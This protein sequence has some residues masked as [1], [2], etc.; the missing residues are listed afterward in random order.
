LGRSSRNVLQPYKDQTGRQNSA[1]SHLRTRTYLRRH[2]VLWDRIAHNSNLTRVRRS[3][4]FPSEACCA[5]RAGRRRPS[6]WDAGNF[7]GQILAASTRS[8][9]AS[10]R[11]CAP[12]CL[13]TGCAFTGPT[14]SSQLASPEAGSRRANDKRSRTCT[15]EL[16]TSSRR[17]SV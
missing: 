7:W 14:P 17:I 11:R 12:L 9:F 2:A 8:A 6:P 10:V 3:C 1:D 13:Q 5:D 15:R 4:A 16:A